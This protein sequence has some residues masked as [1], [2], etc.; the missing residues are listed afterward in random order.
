MW[1]K[2]LTVISGERYTAL[3]ALNM[4]G[5]YLLPG[6]FDGRPWQPTPMRFFVFLALFYLMAVLFR[7]CYRYRISYLAA[8][9]DRMDPPWLFR[10]TVF[11]IEWVKAAAGTVLVIWWVG[12]LLFIHD[13]FGQ[14]S[15]VIPWLVGLAHSG[16]IYLLAQLNVN[17]FDLIA[18]GATQD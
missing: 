5:L 2:A 16:L 3:F 10:L 15:L 7:S 12:G 1:Q 9:P 8:L 17:L 6:L 13:F 11:C 4:A 14:H 18:N